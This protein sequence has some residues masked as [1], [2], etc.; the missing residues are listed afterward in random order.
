MFVL[1][2]LMLVITPMNVAAK[3]TVHVDEKCTVAAMTKASNNPEE[4]EKLKDCTLLYTGKT[5]SWSSGVT[6]REVVPRWT[7]EANTD[8]VTEPPEIIESKKQLETDPVQKS[9][10]QKLLDNVE[11]YLNFEGQKVYAVPSKGDK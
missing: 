8:T 6:Y 1:I 2:F 3:E 9:L 5:F 11:L 7:K 4:L 10:R